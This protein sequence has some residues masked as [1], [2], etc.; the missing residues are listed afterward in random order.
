MEPC[1]AGTYNPFSGALALCPTG[2]LRKCCVPTGGIGSTC[3][4][5]DPCDTGGCLSEQSGY[6]TGGL[7]TAACDPRMDTCPAYAVC[8][9]VLFSAALGTCMLPCDRDEQCR[10][11]WSCQAF[12]RMPFMGSSET[13]NVCWE[14]GGMTGL[15]GIGEPCARDDECLSFL[16][17]PGPGGANRCTATCD[18]ANPC[19]DGFRCTLGECFR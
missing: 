4:N 5:A 8:I 11:S 15:A 19:I 6:P 12:P 7:C 16:C 3:T 9:P 1:P 10:E 17:R 18:G 14:P 13:I 2:A